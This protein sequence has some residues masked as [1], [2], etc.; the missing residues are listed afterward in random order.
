MTVSSS[1]SAT[2]LSTGTS[3]SPPT[4]SGAASGLDTASLINSLVSV[5]QNQQV[6]LQQQQA[7]IQARSAA[8]TNLA[9]SLGTLSTQAADLANTS[10][11]TGATA[12]SSATDVTATATGLQAASLTFDVTSI[13]QAHTLVSA[14][15]VSSTSAQ[16][17]SGPLTLTRSD[18]T[19]ASIGVG[20]GS[21]SDVV[22]S[23]NNAGDG[24]VAAAV[25]TGP[26]AFRLQ[27]QTA[28]TGAASSFTLSGLDGFSS[29]S[30][31][32]TGA[33]ATLHL[34]GTSGAAYD[35]TSASNTFGSLVPGLSFTV[36]KPD[37]G[38]TV[39]STVDGTAVA[40]KVTALVATANSILTN[41]Q[42]QA[43]YD[44]STNVGGPFTGDSTTDQLQQQ[45]LSL[46]GETNAPG[47]AVTRDGAITFDQTAFLTAFKANPNQVAQAFGAAGTFAP[48][49]GLTGTSA[50]LSAALGSARAGTYALQVN[51]APAAE[52]W[53]IDP[54]GADISGST[55]SLTRGGA[56]VSYTVP[57]MGETLDQ[58]AAGF[59]AASATAQFG[60]TAKVVGTAL[61]FTADSLG[62]QPAFTATLDGTAGTQLTAG[63]DVSGTI[64][65]QAAIGVG[66]TLSLPTGTGGAVGLSVQVTTT[67]ADVA[68]SGG[69]IGSI[70][71]SPG[72]AQS[73]I[74]LVRGAIDP[75]TGSLTTAESGAQTQIKTYQTDINDWTTK[76]ND[77]R[78][79]LTT[80]F[81]AMETALA[82][83]KAQ[84]A[85]IASLVTSSG[86][87]TT[88]MNGTLNA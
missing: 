45:I 4:L 11:W 72:L 87:T 53:Q 68:A 25:Q 17:A 14:N 58:T 65:G 36:S 71:Y 85:A 82:T 24:L 86:G 66:G 20:S 44:T 8:Y 55:L 28:A 5:E 63:A 78:A 76:L 12:T 27:V 64:D 81:T 9:S 46:V 39:A 79:S 34:G 47:V 32:T 51:T 84:T 33:D 88:L 15:S 2:S 38:V 80:Q 6:L 41:I 37:T 16:A 21:L 10:A 30:V 23:I 18:G 83:L 7:T 61:Q 77:Y 50:T 73:M 70:T 1:T 3:T 22:S 35:V 48:A 52:S 43:A 62:S 13:A 74:G 54:A 49:A 26:G 69:A 56:S 29:M 60:V 75:Q 42:S 19:T 67:A 59:N 57:S 31:L 40:A